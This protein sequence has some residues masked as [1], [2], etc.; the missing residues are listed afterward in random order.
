MNNCELKC[1]HDRY[2]YALTKTSKSIQKLIINP[3]QSKK[4]SSMDKVT[5]DDDEIR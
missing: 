3:K 1:I 5:L 4:L 2:P